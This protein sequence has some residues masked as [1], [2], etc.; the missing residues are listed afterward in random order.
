MHNNYIFFCSHEKTK[1]SENKWRAVFSQWRHSLFTDENN[2]TYN[3]GE[4]YM[5]YQKALLMGDMDAANEIISID[6]YDEAC[7]NESKVLFT[8]ISKIKNIGRKIKNFDQ[9]L[10][11][12]HKFDIVKKGN[13]YKFSQNPD[14]KE[15]LISTKNKILAEASSYDN[16]W[17]IG[18][19][20]SDAITTDPSNYGENLLGKALMCVRSEL[21]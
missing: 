8:Q 18:L 4:Q 13:Y 1:Y 11:D 9:K 15:I 12:E 6:I 17:G 10:W 20:E 21:V 14:L 3:S 16:I 5:M 19:S 7:K 2:I